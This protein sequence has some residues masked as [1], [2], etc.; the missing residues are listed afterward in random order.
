VQ[1]PRRAYTL[2]EVVLTMAVI[3]IAVGV[4]FPA[5]SS[6]YTQQRL[7]AGTDTVRAAW[8]NARTH[9]IEEARPYRFSVVPGKG[10]FRIAP[11]DPSFWSG[12]P[13]QIDSDH[14]ALIIEDALPR[15]MRFTINH[16]PVDKQGDSVLES[17][18]ASQWKTIA[19]FETDGTSQED[20]EVTLGMDDG[21]GRPLVILL[22][23]VT[24]SSSVKN[25]DTQ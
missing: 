9:A 14:P 3:V 22:R 10:N 21:S 15:G 13:P 25:G 12:S 17:V 19:V 23:G 16:A 18:S 24:G 8:V 11:D 7:R 4:S 6:M 20:V 2:L 1:T 5:V